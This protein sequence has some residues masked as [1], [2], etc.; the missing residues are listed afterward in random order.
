MCSFLSGTYCKESNPQEHNPRDFT[1]WKVSTQTHNAREDSFTRMG[2]E[3]SGRAPVEIC[4]DSASCKGLRQ[5]QAWI[6]TKITYKKYLYLLE[7]IL[8]VGGTVHPC[9]D[10]PFSITVPVG[11]CPFMPWPLPSSPSS[12]F[13]WGTVHP[14]LDSLFP[15]A[16]FL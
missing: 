9:S 10:P 12:L 16:S 11:H 14:Y 4:L 8:C 5:G 6:K 1:T 7:F 13:L 3:E 15:L 2:R